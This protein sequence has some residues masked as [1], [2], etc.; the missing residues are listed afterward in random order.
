[1]TDLPEQVWQAFLAIEDRRFYLHPGIDGRGMIRAA[2]RNLGARAVREGGSTITQQLAKQ[3][4][5]SSDRTVGRKLKEV[6]LALWLDARLSKD[7]ILERYLSTIYFGDNVYGLRAAAKHY[8]DVE[9]EDL[10]IPEA[11]L[12]A[13]LVKAPSRLAPTKNLSA[14]RSRADLVLAAMVDAGVLDAEEAATLPPPRLRSSGIKE[15][16]SGS[17]FTDWLLSSVSELQEGEHGQLVVPTTLDSRLQSLAVTMVSRAN[18]ESAQ[19]AL[20][21][22]RPDGRIVAMVGGRSYSESPFNRATQAQRQPGSTFKLF[23]YL[24]AL[25]EGLTPD[26][27]LRDEPITVGDWSPANADGNYRGAI[28]MKEAFAISS[29]VA[30]VRLAEKI[31]RRKVIRTAQSFGISSNLTS[32]PSIALGTSTTTLL[33]MTAA[34][35]GVAGN[36][37]AVRPYGIPKESGAGGRTSLD[38]ATTLPMMRELLW[39]AANVGTGRAAALRTPTFGKTGTTQDNRDAIF[40][41]FAQ[42]LVTAVWVGNDDNRP[43]R[44]VA[45]GGLPARIWR[46]FMAQALDSRPAYRVTLAPIST[47]ASSGTSTR[48]SS[49]QSAGFTRPAPKTTDKTVKRGKG[50]G[51]GKGQGRGKG[52]GKK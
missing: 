31:G 42:D 51:R 41:G 2:W 12:L 21:A 4:F 44:N 5:L 38:E 28:T 50:K 30:T 10:S 26:T 8:F 22:M 43:L 11:A 29:N 24:A 33:E 23:V 14:A 20:V 36:R 9:P 18:L 16:P 45:G 7:Q 47:P 49:R 48:P 34:Y 19:V 37:F 6:V 40:V 35:A 1:V 27:L 13:G 39:S 3:S 15:V 52:K 25:Q 32:Q 46:D 17:Y